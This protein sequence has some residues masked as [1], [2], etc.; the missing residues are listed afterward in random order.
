MSLNCFLKTWRIL[1][2]H[3]NL[4]HFRLL[5]KHYGLKQENF[6][7]AYKSRLVQR[8]DICFCHSGQWGGISRFSRYYRGGTIRLL[9]GGG[10]GAFSPN[11]GE[12]CP[13]GLIL[14]LQ[15]IGWWFLGAACN[16]SG[17]KVHGHVKIVTRFPASFIGSK[18]SPLPCW[19]IW[20][21]S[22]WQ[23]FFLSNTFSLSRTYWR[24][25]QFHCSFWLE[26]VNHMFQQ[27]TLLFL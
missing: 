18:L 14:F 15:A 9:R 21:V 22:N 25:F 5:Q 6:P 17:T 1:V 19:L 12:A 4:L 11:N 8:D 16:Y 26:N 3:N 24:L 13:Q 10:R 2:W 20:A 23:C 27:V 7:L